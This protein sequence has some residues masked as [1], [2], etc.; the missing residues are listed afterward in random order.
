MAMESSHGHMTQTRGIKVILFSDVVDS[1]GRMFA[2]E[3]STVS[4][5]DRD[6]DV[7]R[8]HLEALGGELSKNTGDGILATFATT[9][10][11]LDFLQN[12]L[13]DL[14]K[15]EPPSLQHRFGLHIGEIYIKDDDILGQGVHLAARLQTISPINGVAFTEGT[16]ANLDPRYRH[17]ATS[18][19]SL[20][21]KGL[22]EKIRCHAIAEAVFL[23]EAIDPSSH[24]QWHSWPAL[25]QRLSSSTPAQ[26]FASSC[27]LLL[28]L[29]GDL[30]PANSV[31]SF[32]LD[33]RLTIQK[34]W[35]ERT[36]QI[37][38]VRTAPPVVL[39][40]SSEPIFPRNELAELL[41][42]L[43]PGRFPGVALDFVLDRVG[44]DP[45]AMGRLAEVIRRQ[46]RPTLVVGYFGSESRVEQAGL[47]SSPL[48]DLIQSGITARDLSIGTV[49]GAGPVMPAP[50]QL[51]R[52]IGKDNFASAIASGGAHA[53]PADSVIDWSLAWDAML[54]VEKPHELR[55]SSHTMVVVGR[56]SEN[57]VRD[58]DLFQTPAAFRSTEPVWGGSS[59]EMPGVIL[60]VVVGQSLA[61][62][63]WLTPLSTAACTA[64][65]AGLG[66]L[67]AALQPSR[68]WRLLTLALLIPMA[69]LFSL[70]LAISARMLLPLTVP[71]LAV[72]S[73]CLLRRK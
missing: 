53:I 61:L 36:H 14:H 72:V 5:I 24:R 27:L 21:L 48:P 17:R 42:Q 26:A 37:G 54:R 64:L 6:L 73:T 10:Q 41:E 57:S 8:T 63:H 15:R 71:T 60:Q 65:S 52:P 44:S 67:L 7:L 68:P 23:D 18:L 40:E 70:Q 32:L 34:M 58:A 1:S 46:R 43:P 55:T 59:G 16:Y 56:F 39:L 49:A 2:D 28:A 38:P 22:P 12:A 19:G 69:A 11:A 50:L 9:S 20:K 62:R 29:V 25:C 33:R 13:R 30:D 47:R 3:A 35:R 31:S 66:L 4:L 51:L 45:A